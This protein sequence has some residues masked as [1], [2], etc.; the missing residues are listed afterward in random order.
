MES[1]ALFHSVINQSLIYLNLKQTA[2]EIASVAKATDVIDV[3]KQ[4]KRFAL[5]VTLSNFIIVSF[6]SN[7]TGQIYR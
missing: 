7:C 5:D 4:D 3:L 6:F 1:V 2:F